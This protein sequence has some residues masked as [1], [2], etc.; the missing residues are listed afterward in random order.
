M[1]LKVLPTS[2]FRCCTPA[3]LNDCQAPHCE[4]LTPHKSEDYSLWMC[5]WHPRRLNW[6]SRLAHRIGPFSFLSLVRK[7]SE[8]RTFEEAASGGTN[9]D[10]GPVTSSV[11]NQVELDLRAKIKLP[12]CLPSELSAHLSSLPVCLFSVGYIFHQKEMKYRPVCV[13]P[14]PPDSL[15]HCNT[16]NICND[17]WAVRD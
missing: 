4:L 6:L 5:F 3:P 14:K 9:A 11:A 12:N 15:M 13:S 17:Q 1:K 8:P 7:R 10:S 16:I 2:A